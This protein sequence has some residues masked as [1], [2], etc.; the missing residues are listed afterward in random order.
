MPQRVCWLLVRLLGRAQETLSSASATWPTQ[1]QPKLSTIN[2]HLP[3]MNRARKLPLTGFGAL[4]AAI[5]FVFLFTG[6]GW[7]ISLAAFGV[8]LVTFILGLRLY[9]KRRSKIQDR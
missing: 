4:G 9:H 6:F 5:F 7:P 3:T 1:L 8:Y 2:N